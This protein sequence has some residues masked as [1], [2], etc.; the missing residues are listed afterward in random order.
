MPSLSME[1]PIFPFVIVSGTISVTVYSRM[2]MCLALY[3]ALSVEWQ[4]TFRSET[5]N[6]QSNK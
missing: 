2:I 3:K 5:R 4:M 6:K 1:I